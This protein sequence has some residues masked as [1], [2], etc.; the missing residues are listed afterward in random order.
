M[1]DADV[2]G[3]PALT[4]ALRRFAPSLLEAPSYDDTPRSRLTAADL[5]GTSTAVKFS[6]RVPRPAAL[7]IAGLESLNRHEVRARAENTLVTMYVHSIE[8][9]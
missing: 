2:P 4:E 3:T 6:W 9:F 1:P 7:T 5:Q 8:C